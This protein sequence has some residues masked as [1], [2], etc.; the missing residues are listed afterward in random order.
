MVAEVILE[1]SGLFIGT[2]GYILK[3][4]DNTKDIG[5]VL[6]YTGLGLTTAGA[7]SLVFTIP[8]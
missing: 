3:Q 6:F 8:F 4:D 2:L 5:N 1:L 7:V